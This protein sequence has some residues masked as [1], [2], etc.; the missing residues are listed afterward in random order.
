VICGDRL[1]GA[2]G[3]PAC[4]ARLSAG[5]RSHPSRPQQRAILIEPS[6]LLRSDEGAI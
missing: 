5:S 3:S 6:G 2:S 1:P 4:S